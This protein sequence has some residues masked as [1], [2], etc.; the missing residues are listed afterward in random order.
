MKRS[1]TMAFAAF[2]AAAPLTARA[3]T[4]EFSFETD[5]FVISGVLTA[6]DTLNSAGGYDITGISGNVSSQGGGA[7]TGLIAKPGQPAPSTD[8]TGSWNYDDVVFGSG[9]AFDLYGVLFDAGAGA[10]SYSYNLYFDGTVAYLSTRNPA[11]NFWGEAGELTLSAV[12]EPAT[13]L[14]IGIGFAALGAA[15]RRVRNRDRLAT[16]V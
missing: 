14:M 5:G 12:P 7:I 15:G 4:M 3:S 6:S 16:I 8:S 13:W 10:D 11:G 1:L 2:L 9:P